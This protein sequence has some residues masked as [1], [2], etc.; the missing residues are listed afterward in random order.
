[1]TAADVV[2]V[3]QTLALL[4]GGA[5]AYMRFVWSRD[6]HPRVT[7]HT[8][9]TVLGPQGQGMDEQ[10]LGIVTVSV[11][12]HGGVRL[13]F[14]K[15]TVTVL[16]LT[17]TDT[18]K[19]GGKRLLGQPEFRDD[20]GVND[21]RLFPAPWGY[22]FVDAGGENTYRSVVRLPTDTSY[23]QVQARLQYGDDED[24]DFHADSAVV[25]VS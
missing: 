3:V 15:A 14:R 4:I 19:D 24:S 20:T 17:L 18:L 16:R 23:V 7:M 1:M 2:D 9:F 11:R 25:R 12:N 10:L 13:R 21:R 22:S 6:R 8:G 5:W